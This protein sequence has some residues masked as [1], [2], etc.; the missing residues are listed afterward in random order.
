MKQ[1]QQYAIEGT[2]SQGPNGYLYLLMNFFLL[3]FLPIL[4]VIGDFITEGTPMNWG[5]VGKW[6][7][8][9][10]IGIRLFLAGIKQAS[11]P[12]FTASGIF[13]I[14]NRESFVVI[15]ELGFA[16]TSLGVMGI[17]SVINS[18]WRL[19]ASVTG[20]LYFGL[21]GIQHAFRKPDSKNEVVALLYDLAVFLMVFFYLVFTLIY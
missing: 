10:A 6:F 2:K 19:L 5:S 15:R 9:W 7:I 17:L 4:S 18:D 16:N 14:K 11:S 20:G 13:N 3:V 21:A 8:F 1:Q 12:A